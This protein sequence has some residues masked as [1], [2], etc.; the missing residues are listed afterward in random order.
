MTIAKQMARTPMQRP[1]ITPRS[2][3]EDRIERLDAFVYI[4]WT[5]GPDYERAFICFDDGEPDMCDMTTTNYK[6]ALLFAEVY[7]AARADLLEACRLAL[8]YIEN[9]ESELGITLDSGNALRA[10]LTD[11]DRKEK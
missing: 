9:T 6:G 5:S 7:R 8:N 2:K 3:H 11:A 4:R 1:P 10:A